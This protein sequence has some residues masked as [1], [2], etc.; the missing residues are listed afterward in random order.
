[1]KLLK[2]KSDPYYSLI[3]QAVNKRM[4]DPKYKKRVH[5]LLK[6]IELNCGENALKAIRNKIPSYVGQAKKTR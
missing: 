5:K 4:F 6:V 1:M 2:E 3:L